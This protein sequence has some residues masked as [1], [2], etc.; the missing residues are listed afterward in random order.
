MFTFVDFGYP[1]HAGTG[2]CP[3]D[4]YDLFSTL[5]HEFSHGMGLFSLTTSTGASKIDSISKTFTGQ[6][7]L[8]R[9]GN[10]KQLWTLPGPTFNGVPA[11]LTG[12]DGG[13]V[14]AGPRATELLGAPP[15]VYAP[16]PFNSS[17]ISHLAYPGS[18][19]APVMLPFSPTGDETRAYAPFELG[20][21]EDLGYRTILT[22][23]SAHDWQLWR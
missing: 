9:T 14:V 7:Q 12:A 16:D 2:P 5:L 13:V 19:P 6:D 10:G 11:D 1:W 4:Q 8:L 15:P 23:S 17:S 20:I 21:L 18:G 22:R 3:S